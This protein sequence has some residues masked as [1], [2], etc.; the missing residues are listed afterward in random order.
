MRIS[1]KDLQKFIDHPPGFSY[2]RMQV[3]YLEKRLEKF[4]R[5]IIGKEKEKASLYIWKQLMKF[6]NKLVIQIERT[7]SQVLLEYKPGV[8]SFPA[9][10][11]KI[12]IT[13]EG[14]II[15]T[16][17]ITEKEWKKLFKESLKDE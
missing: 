3:Q 4:I 6:Y 17:G 10:K 11:E 13:K 9:D 12:T 2:D 7:E 1:N 15:L 8:Y 14:E 16:D 5:V